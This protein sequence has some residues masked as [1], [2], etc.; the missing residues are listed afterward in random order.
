MSITV[1]SPELIHRVTMWADA[2]G[3]SMEDVIE[4]AL[5]NYLD[6]KE[7]EAIHG[8]RMPFDR[9]KTNCALPIQGCMWQC[10][11]KG[12]LMRIRIQMH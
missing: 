3:E 10:C 6:K 12:S 9:Y 2:L 5:Q 11:T 7:A 4:D 8:E 1:T